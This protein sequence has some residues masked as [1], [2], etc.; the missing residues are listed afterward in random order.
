MATIKAII[1]TIDNLSNNKEQVRILRSDPLIDEIIVVN[2]GSIDGTQ[3]WLKSQNDLTIVNR[4]NKGAGPG[5]NAGLDKAEKFDYVLMLDGGIRPLINGTRQM[6]DYLQDTPEAD[7]IG[8]EIADFETDANKAWRRWPEP[9]IKTY[10]N[11]RLSHTAYCL[12]RYKVFDGL[13]FCEEGPFAEPGWGA[14]DDE[15]MFQWQEV[16]IVVHVVTNVHPYR[17][18]SG[19]FGR[20]YQE[21]GIWPTQY[22]SVYEKRVVWLHQ[23]WPQYEPVGQWGEPWLTVVIKVSD[24][25][26]TA[27]LIKLAHDELRKRRFEPPFSNDWN[28]YHIVTWGNESWWLDWAKSRRLRQHHGDAVIVD[29]KTIKRSSENEAAWT[30][31]FILY[32]GNNW[33]DA[34]RPNAFYYGLVE[35]EQDLRQL[36]IKYNDTHPPQLT[37]KLPL[38]KGL[39]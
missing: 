23:N 7:V 32:E 9:I 18:A 14:D 12:A 25:E 16:G 11:T 31:D 38:D 37:K 29:G 4:E 22:G 8:V 30:G 28:P 27:K 21:T 35:N 26:T 20:L 39:L 34:I 17:H 6:L 1:T 10:Q 19:S 36:L 2:N 3:E 5:R 33:Q 13:R 15:M 24:I